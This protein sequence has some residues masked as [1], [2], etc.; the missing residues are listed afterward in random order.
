[1]PPKKSHN[2]HLAARH[3]AVAALDAALQ[4]FGAAQRFVPGHLVGIKGFSQFDELLVVIFLLWGVDR[5]RGLG[6]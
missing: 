1:M 4:L 5:G 6:F 3:G 2:T